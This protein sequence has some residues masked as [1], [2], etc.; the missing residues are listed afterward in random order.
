M[1]EWYGNWQKPNCNFRKLLQEL[2]DKAP[3]RHEITAEEQR[4]LSTLESIAE[5]LM[6]GE[7]VQN[8]QLQTWLSEDEYVQTEVFKKGGVRLGLINDL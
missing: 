2:M 1:S 5:K 7:N 4:R 3:P 6:R 8:R